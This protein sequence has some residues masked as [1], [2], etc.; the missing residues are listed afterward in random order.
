M[1]LPVWGAQHHFPVHLADVPGQSHSVGPEFQQ[2]SV[3]SGVQSGSHCQQVVQGDICG[4]RS[5]TIKDHPQLGGRTALFVYS[6]HWQVIAVLQW[7]VQL[8]LDDQL[9]MS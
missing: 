3:Q 5:T 7:S 1:Q 9:G 8:L 2:D 4:G 6:M